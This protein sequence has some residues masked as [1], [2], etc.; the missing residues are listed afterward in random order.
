MADALINA[1][2]KAAEGA[3]TPVGSGDVEELL[4]SFPTL[5]EVV[6]HALHSLCLQI[7]L[8]RQGSLAHQ[9]LLT[10]SNGADQKL[11]QEVTQDDFEATHKLLKDD[12]SLALKDKG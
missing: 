11:N 8:V 12:I 10:N 3:L 7:Q 4:E 6:V 9:V 5:A 2:D 1:K